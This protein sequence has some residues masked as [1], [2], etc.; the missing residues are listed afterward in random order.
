MGRTLEPAGKVN[1]LADNE[2]GN[3]RAKG[4]LHD[5]KKNYKKQ[6]LIYEKSP[7]FLPWKVN[8]AGCFRSN[9]NFYCIK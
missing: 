7:C 3:E 5:A 2:G 8:G 9:L 1:C 6:K 4:E